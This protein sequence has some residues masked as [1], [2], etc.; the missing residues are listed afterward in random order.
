MLAVTFIACA[1]PAVLSAQ[2]VG[3]APAQRPV[4]AAPAQKNQSTEPANP[5]IITLG[6]PQQIFQFRR[7]ESMGLFNVPDMHTAVLQQH[8]QSY[9]LW[10]T[11]NIGPSGGSIA[12]LATKDF[13]HYENA[14]PGTPR[15]AQ[16]V[17]TPSCRTPLPRTRRRPNARHGMDPDDA[18]SSASCLQ[19]ADADY[20]G[21]NSVITAGNGRDLLMFY[22][23]GNKTLGN[24]TI[25]HG[26]EYNVMMLARSAD[27]GITWKREGVI[28][29]GTDP[30]PIDQTGTTQ[31]GISEP[32]TIVANGYIY[33]F[34]QYVP[35]RT[36]DPEA[37]SVIQVARAPV[38]G[39]GAPGTWL[40]Y[41]QGSFS[42]PG[43]GGRGSPIVATGDGT[44]CTRPVQVWPAF[45]TYLNAYVLTF[46]CN[47][48]WFF[49]T[50]TDL[51]TWSA[52][53]NFMPMTMWQHCR[54]MDWNFILVTPGNKAG[55]I[56]Q[57][58]YVLYAH[59]DSRGRGCST[60]FSPHMPWVRSFRFSRAP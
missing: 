7:P 51:I 45:S 20:V 33:M 42:Q 14:G 23:G 30:K 9:L 21:A 38:S 4:V 54:P 11:G 1:L 16:P 15:R 8:D 43:L 34:Y 25:R 26:W 53:T 37:P 50:S 13:F 12:R 57:T 48:G 44:A 19:N 39:D 35:N 59:T 6:E 3:P 28:L 40:K 46:L 31:P 52:A 29:S 2:A 32:G 24:A 18:T 55:V 10:I 5:V 36:S 58:G 17:M 27:N 60:G 22:E 41:Y 56:G 49:S 47:E